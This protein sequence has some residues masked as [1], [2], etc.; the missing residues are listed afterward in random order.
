MTTLQPLRVREA[1]AGDIEAIARVML[2][3]RRAA[4]ERFPP[5]VHD[6]AELVPH[7]LR[8][9][10]PVAEAWVA[11]RDSR[12]V[13]VL[14]LE[15]DLLDSLYVTPDAQGRGI[16]TG[17]LALAK[18][19]R[20]EGLR[21]WVFVSNEPARALYER[22]GFVVIGGSDGEANEEGAPDLLLA[23]SPTSG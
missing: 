8:D 6:D 12:V 4:G 11:E 1:G 14:V 21:L 18:E 15:N 3:A 9:V 7:L 10:L 16:G 20:P 19:R 17:L 2:D 5:S 23:W 13:G 22:H